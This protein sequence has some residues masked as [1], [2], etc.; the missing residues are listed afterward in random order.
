M[1]TGR[2]R[3][4]P[5]GRPGWTTLFPRPPQNDFTP[6]S[7][8]RRKKDVSPLN[9]Q[10][11]AILTD[12][13]ADIPAELAAQ[14]QIF[15]LPLTISFGE[16]HFRDGVDIT[17]AQVY[18]RMAEEL[19]KTS[20]PSGETIL[21]LFAQMREQGYEKVL[22]ILF[23]S[24]LSGTYQAV[25]LM[26]EGFPGLEVA[27]F[28][29]RSGSLGTGLTVLEAARFVEEGR[30]WNEICALIPRLIANTTVFFCVDTLEYLQK[31]GRIGKITAI[32][33]TMLQ[34]KPI[35]SFTPAG[36]LISVAK[37]RG[38]AQS[39]ER[40]TQLAADCYQPGRRCNI[41]TA[42][43]DA[44]EDGA[45]AAKLLRQKVPA[46][47]RHFEGIVDCTLG[48]HTGPHLIG[49]GLQLLDDDM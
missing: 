29:T 43:G 16:E 31:G 46:Y 23:S 8:A 9:P 37:V 38:R 45:K 27:A 34:I 1:G 30:T 4:V 18:R 48:S 20:L 21:G 7:R 26:G 14:H 32:A 33:G 17:P 28:D 11:I 49:A 25:K 35:I 40:V 44:P 39:I 6:R 13:C 42:H 12:T 3:A 47:Q 5:V 15:T 36:E 19:P 10:K 22:A 41:A 24:G 2:G